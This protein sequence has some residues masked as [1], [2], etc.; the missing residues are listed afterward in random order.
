MA[1]YGADVRVKV[2]NLSQLTKLSDKLDQVN[3]KV[4][5]LNASLQ[6]LGK[7]FTAPKVDI[8]TDQALKKLQR[9]NK[10]WDKLERRRKLK[11]IPDP[12]GGGGGGGR[13]GGGG[14]FGANL[15]KGGLAGAGLGLAGPL[16]GL[17]GIAA[18]A[19]NPV[20]LLGAGLGVAA[21]AGV[22]YANAAAKAAAETQKFRQAL[23]GITFGDDYAKALESINKLSD[24]FQQDVNETTK[25]FTKLTAAATAN[26]LSIQET[27][28]IYQGLAAANVALGGDNE[29]LQGIL[30]ATGQVLSKGKVQAEELRGQIGERLPGAFALFAESVG[31]TPAQ[32]DKALEKGEVTVEDFLKFTQDLFKRFGENAQE[33]VN[34]PALAGQRLE[35]SLGD[36][37]RN[38]GTLLQPIGAAFQN[39]F[40]DIID[41]INGAIVALTNFLGIGTEGAIAKA[42]RSIQTELDNIARYEKLIEQGAGGQGGRG[43]RYETAL[44]TAKGELN[45]QID[46]LQEL[47]KKAKGLA[48]NPPTK[49]EGSD[50]GGGG[51]SGKTP[52]ESNAPALALE[53]DLLEKQNRVAQSTVGV[54]GKELEQL[55]LI[56]AEIQA[57]LKYENRKAEIAQEDLYADER[58]LENLIN[59]RTLEREL[60][61]LNRQKLE[62]AWLDQEAKKNALQNL[63]DQTELLKARLNGTEDEVRLKQ[64][65]AAI[66]KDI[67][68]LT[69]GEVLAILEKNKALEEQV[70]I[71]NKMKQAY[72]QVAGTIASEF[73]NAFTSLIDGSKSAQEAVSDMLKNIGEAFISMATEVIAKQLVMITLQ[74]ILKALGGPSSNTGKTPDVDAIEGLSGIGANTDVSNLLP[75]A[76]GGPVGANRPYLIGERGPELFVPNQSGRVISSEAMGSY[77]PNGGMGGGGG[78]VN[79][80][81]SGPQLNF[82]GD[83]YVPKSAVGEIINEAAKKGAVLGEAR[84]INNMRNNRTTRMRAGV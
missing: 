63:K 32:L 8:K 62:I 74:A 39:V 61:E 5:Y 72:E 46:L 29:R 84:T 23:K 52:R 78:S 22:D 79:V 4:N 30:L 26:G 28:E 20:T 45:R 12:G 58:A 14:A 34:G 42:Q 2:I 71:A 33:I 57:R 16:G 36:L 68:S 10:E 51:S 80:N 76:N 67:D 48:P 37:Q 54:F 69:E 82:N 11:P 55:N 75:R 18:S 15:L 49:P 19:L 77:M 70:E 65:A 41:A 7:K 60:I 21:V 35:K 47:Q 56:N 83:E 24:D 44:S 81:Y 59:E 64:Q 43:R 50:L 17:A 73:A 25:Q 13:R 40:R 27:E 38:V 53:L 6:K 3:K 66:A 1:V 31:K 9:L